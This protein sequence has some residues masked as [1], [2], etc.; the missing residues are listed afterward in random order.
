MVHMP[1]ARGLM[2][3]MNIVHTHMSTHRPTATI[4]LDYFGMRHKTASF[5]YSPDWRDPADWQPMDE[6]G[7]AGNDKI[8]LTMD[9]VINAGWTDS[10]SKLLSSHDK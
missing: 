5:A 1:E 8:S 2:V 4:G 9:Q 3:R 6:G 7:P 10:N